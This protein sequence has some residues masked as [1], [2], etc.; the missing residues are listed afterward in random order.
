[1]PQSTDL[2]AKLRQLIGMK[3]TIARN[4]CDLKNFGFGEIR[5]HPTGRGT[6]GQYALHLQCAWRL[7]DG[8]EVITGSGDRHRPIAEGLQTD[9]R[10]LRFGDLQ[11]KKLS[12][13]LRGSD[14]ETESIL[15]TTDL[16]VVESVNLRP[17]GAFS[18]QLSGGLALDVLPDASS[19]EDGFEAW[20]LFVPGQDDSHIVYP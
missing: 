14:P 17:A 7:T 11:S 10:D 1:M 16:L 3:L 20:R 13:L 18:L 12:D 15:N 5:P 19:L 2:L 9:G 6:V 4:A 8:H